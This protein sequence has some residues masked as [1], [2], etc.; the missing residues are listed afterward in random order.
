MCLQAL[1]ETLS[2]DE[3]EARTNVEKILQFYGGDRAAFSLIPPIS[4]DGEPLPAVHSIPDLFRSMERLHFLIQNSRGNEVTLQIGTDRIRV[5]RRPIGQGVKAFVYAVNDSSVVI[6]IPRPTYR[7]LD[8]VLYE[9]KIS[10][11]AEALAKKDPRLRIPRNIYFHPLGLYSQK[12]RVPGIT[13]SEF[14]LSRGLFVKG[15]AGSS[16]VLANNGVREKLENDSEFED[17]KR[18]VETILMLRRQHPRIVDDI[19]PSNFIW[20]SVHRRLAFVDL[21]PA[22]EATSRIYDTVGDFDGYL[23]EAI[24]ALNRYLQKGSLDFAQID[25]WIHGGAIVNCESI[26]LREAI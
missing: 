17:I 19:G 11:E 4:V 23:L 14:F 25:L 3:I 2:P 9:K 13:L 24:R 10:F 8:S 18:Q 15:P 21:G 16:I 12:E 1:A 26:F 5:N 7:G 6:K 22:S 20:D